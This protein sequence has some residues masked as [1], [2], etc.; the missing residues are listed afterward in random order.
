MLAAGAV[1]CICAFAG[2]S[3]SGLSGTAP[4][5]GKVTYNGQPVEGAVVS[6]LGEGEGARVATAISG[7]GGAYELMTVD[8]EGAMPGKYAVTVTKSE[9][10]VGASQSMEEAA[11]SLAPPP[12]AKELLPAKYGDPA[13]TPLKFDVKA[14]A[15]TI[16]LALT[17]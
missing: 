1:V 9:A 3:G 8:E 15:N 13:Q 12:V 14:G 4:V 5:T 16:D 6:F 2:C 17:D 7:A 10:A 11:K